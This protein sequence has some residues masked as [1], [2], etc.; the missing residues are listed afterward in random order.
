MLAIPLNCARSIQL[1]WSTNIC[2]IKCQTFDR[3]N[4]SFNCAGRDPGALHTFARTSNKN[5]QVIQTKLTSR[6]PFIICAKSRSQ[7][8]YL[9]ENGHK[10]TL[11]FLVFQVEQRRFSLSKIGSQ[12]TLLIVILCF[13]SPNRS[14]NTPLRLPCFFCPYIN[15][16][17]KA[18]KIM[19][20]MCTCTL[21]Q[22]AVHK[23][24]N[25]GGFVRTLK[26]DARYF[27]GNQLFDRMPTTCTVM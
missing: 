26:S 21:P 5:S 20:E 18:K 23:L 22:G 8:L 12:L 14:S 3:V 11:Y 2:W 27:W 17:P 10:S 19:S 16:P 6:R 1:W 15:S 24:H 9:S 13:M 25:C 7:C 4:C